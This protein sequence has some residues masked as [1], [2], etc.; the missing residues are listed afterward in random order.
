MGTLRRPPGRPQPLGSAC[1][2]HQPFPARGEP[3]RATA[4]Q[5]E[6][7]G[8][9]PA[10]WW[11]QD[12]GSDL[13]PLTC[14]LNI[15]RPGEFGNTGG[16]KGYQVWST[17]VGTVVLSEPEGSVPKRTCGWLSLQPKIVVDGT[18]LIDAGLPVGGIRTE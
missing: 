2:G 11:G 15:P 12:L 5:L 13:N 3:G 7:T 10:E 8:A 9:I 14:L 17:G 4:V 16:N 6:N 1:R 18:R